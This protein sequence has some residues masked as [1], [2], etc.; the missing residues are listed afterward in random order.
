MQNKTES[1]IANAAVQIKIQ[2]SKKIKKQTAVQHNK[3][4]CRGNTDLKRLQA[5]SVDVLET[6]LKEG[7]KS[8]LLLRRATSTVTSTEINTMN[9]RREGVAERSETDRLLVKKSLKLLGKNHKVQ[10]SMEECKE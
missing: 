6:R 4:G 1:A 2:E 10:E 8:P 5:M 9:R 7:K 3:D